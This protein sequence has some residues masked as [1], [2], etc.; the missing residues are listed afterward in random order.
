[1]S[2]QI[3]KAIDDGIKS[4]ETKLEAQLKSA[5]EKYEG[6][7]AENGKAYDETRNEV[8]A[9][10]AK[11]EAAIIDLSQQMDGVSSIKE[12]NESIGSQFIKSDA[13][14]ELVSGQREKVRLEVKNTVASDSTTVYEQQIQAVV[15]GIFTPLTIRQLLNSAPTNSNAVT[16]RRESSFTNAAA[17]VSQGATKPESDIAFELKTVPVETVA[18][19]LKVTQQMMA[20]A[21]SLMAYI[22]NRLRF[23]LAARIDAQLLNGNGT[24]PNLS[25]ITDTGNF[26]AYTPGSGDLL[27]DAIN[28]AKY[29]LWAK[30]FAPDAVIVNPADWGAAERTRE[31]TGSGMYLAG[32]PGTNSAM[33]PFGVRIVMSNNMTQGKFAIGTFNQAAMVYNR[34]STTVEVGYVNDDFSRNLLTLRAEERL[35]LAVD[36]PNAILYGDFSA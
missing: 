23:A 3:I 7:V 22:D 27:F 2:D 28:K 20:D 26:V 36:Q 21:P 32:L 16:V 29:L 10:S 4:V 12:S 24:S 5:M 6:Q 30:G 18:T 14:K 31:G 25:G 35:A 13:F 19:T 15:P 17:E 33:N 1:M 11:M 34:Q 8:R 9:L